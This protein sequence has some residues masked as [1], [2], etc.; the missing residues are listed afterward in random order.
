ME[1]GESDNEVNTRKASVISLVVTVQPCEVTKK[2]HFDILNLAT[3][4]TIVEGGS[5][6]MT[7]S[8]TVLYSHQKQIIIWG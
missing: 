8:C 5:A 2:L 6:T 3:F 7:V 4:Q 1:L